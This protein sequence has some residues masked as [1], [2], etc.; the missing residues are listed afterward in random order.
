[1]DI[2]LTDEQQ[3]LID[4]ADAMLRRHCTT[5]VVRAVRSGDPTG[6]L[7]E[8]WKRIVDAGWL[9]LALRDPSG[10]PGTLLELGLIGREAGRHLVPTVFYSVIES[11]V[12]LDRLDETGTHADLLESILGGAVKVAV[13]FGETATERRADLL[14]SRAEPV[15]DGWALELRKTLVRGAPTSDQ[16]IVACSTPDGLGFFVVNA[17][18]VTVIPQATFGHDPHGRVEASGVVLPDSACVGQVGASAERTWSEVRDVMTALTAM[19]LAGSSQALVDRTVEHLKSRQVFGKPL[20]AF[21]AAQHIAADMAIR[22]KGASLAALRAAWAVDRGDA[23]H[24][25]AVA[26]TWAGR[27]AKQNSVWAHQLHAGMGF[28]TETDLHLW[29]DRVVGMDAGYGTAAH[30]LRDLAENLHEPAD[31]R[32]G[33]R[34]GFR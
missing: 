8:L 12:L 31:E 18:D 34:H 3:A 5:D 33:H 25:L 11:V 30:H 4:S 14:E 6:A 19:D 9:E 23:S 22:A 7:D 32:K 21:Q 1:M 2:R 16:L 10:G 27:A 26:K 28:V 20:G 15:H 29:S 13:A 17:A 24:E